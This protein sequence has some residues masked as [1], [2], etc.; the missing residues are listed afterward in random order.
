VLHPHGRAHEPYIPYPDGPA[1]DEPDDVGAR[2]VLVALFLELGAV[3]VAV[4]DA[5]AGD[6]DIGEPFAVDQAAVHVPVRVGTERRRGLGI[7]GEPR[8]AQ[9]RRTVLE[10]ENDAALHEDRPRYEY[11]GRNDDPSSC[12]GACVHSLLY[13]GGID[14][15]AVPDRFIGSDIE[16]RCMSC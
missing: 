8:A 1:L 5:V 14:G 9:Q 10:V 2:A 6:A 15:H 4:D 3:T 12:P 7:V 11:T 16:V 13:R